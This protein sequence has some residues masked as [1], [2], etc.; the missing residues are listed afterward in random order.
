[1]HKIAISQASLD[2]MKT[3]MGKMHPF[4]AIDPGKT[5][6]LAPGGYHLMMQELKGPLKQGDNVTLHFDPWR[7][8]VFGTKGSAEARDETTLTVARIGEAPA[9]QIHESVDSLGM[10]L[11]AF[12]ETIETGKPFPVSTD[13]MLDVVGAFEAVIRSMADGA[14]FGGTEMKLALAPVRSMASRTE[15]KTGM[16]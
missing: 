5:V 1:M 14:P 6:K 10:L 7:V 4:D 2:R 12:A 9:T 11:E 15:P 16:P 3:R 13:D 8:H